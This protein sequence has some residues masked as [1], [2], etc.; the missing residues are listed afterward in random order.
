MNVEA[1]KP[2]GLSLLDFYN[3][4]TEAVVSTCR[5]D[6]WVSVMPA[7]Q[8]FRTGTCLHIDRAA[9]DNCRGR[10]LD[11]GAGTGLHSLYLQNRGL[12]VCAIDILPEACEIMR[13]RGLNEVY[14]MD[15][16]EFSAEPFDT[17]LILGRGIG[18]VEN[19]AGLDSFLTDIHRLVKADGQVL[20]NSLDVRCTT[21]PLHLAYHEATRQAGRYVGEILLYFE[22]KGLRGPT[23]GYLHVDSE[24]L[25]DHSSK[26]GWFCEIL[27]REEDG[28]YLAKLT[29]AG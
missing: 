14:C 2:Y 17:L 10:V 22:Y 1:M 19:L 8:F 3:G 27:T 15:I 6:G 11:I 18:I 5:D 24:T 4:D 16:S 28:N 29:K 12:S 13:G 26:A 23:F 7:S 20:L 21:E 25:A 9:L